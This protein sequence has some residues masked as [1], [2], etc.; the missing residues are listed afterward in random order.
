MNQ[1]DTGNNSNDG[2]AS[3]LATAPYRLTFTI[4]RRCGSPVSSLV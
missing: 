2:A 4:P 1:T 3:V